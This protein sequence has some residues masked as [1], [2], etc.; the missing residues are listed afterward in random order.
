MLQ[1]KNGDLR[2]GKKD[3]HYILKKQG[4]RYRAKNIEKA[5]FRT[6]YGV[7]KKI[8]NNRYETIN[9][10]DKVYA[11]E[12]IFDI[13]NENDIEQAFKDTDIICKYLSKE[14]NVK[15]N[16]FWTG[17]KGT[18]IQI[19]LKEPV[20]LN[21]IGIDGRNS[22]IVK[23]YTLLLEEILD[24]LNIKC[25]TSLIESNRLIQI[26]NKKK[27][28]SE[29]RTFKI[30]IGECRDLNQIREFGAE[31]KNIED[32]NNTYENL[33]FI[34]HL[35]TLDKKNISENALKIL[36]SSD[37]NN[38]QN[39]DDAEQAKI[40]YNTTIDDYD[41]TPLITK[42]KIIHKDNSH[43]KI[44]APISYSCIDYLNKK[45]ANQILEQLKT[46]DRLN[47]PDNNLENSFW[48]AYNNGHNGIGALYNALELNTDLKD[49]T[50]KKSRLDLFNDF[51]SYLEACKQ[52]NEEKEILDN[53]NAF[54][55]LFCKYNNW[56]DM[57]ETEL[58]DYV[59]NTENVFK[60][61]I[62]SLSAL[63]G[64]GSR[65]I[66]VNGGAEV[67]KS[68]YINT[69]KKLMPDFIN[70]GSSTPAS[71]RRRNKEA[72]NKKDS[73]FRR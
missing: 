13:D 53:Y 31:N 70:L 5:T 24:K 2:D 11:E 57:L 25:D 59:D 23:A 19:P 66:V 37:K 32:P 58:Y 69:I 17:K 34:E 35:K 45:Q 62:N 68:E 47:A 44:I 64:Y 29:D 36:E 12:I 22:N 18:N 60:G 28:E 26:P 14:Y 67:G 6:L 71:V 27:D 41:I 10:F 7:N 72:F 49:D 63:L 16:V 42:L 56:F 65:F 1:K 50:E 8:T 51:K 61:L 54:K 52:E 4:Y 46:D 33:D 20:E 39:N 73:L 15:Y 30:S 38:K 55:R 9:K 43:K 40:D 3:I 48:D 21:S